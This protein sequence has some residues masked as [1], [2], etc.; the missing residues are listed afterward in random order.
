[1]VSNLVS[2]ADLTG[3]LRGAMAPIRPGANRCGK[4][5]TQAQAPRAERPTGRRR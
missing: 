4:R 5:V 3:R 1:M 2:I